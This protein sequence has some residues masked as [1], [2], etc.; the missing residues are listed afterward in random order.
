V[1]TSERERK[2]EREREKESEEMLE[3]QEGQYA[4]EVKCATGA[5][6]GIGG[7]MVP[8]QKERCA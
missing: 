8:Q 2:I 7:G 4:R 1:F 5:L 6:T 3:R